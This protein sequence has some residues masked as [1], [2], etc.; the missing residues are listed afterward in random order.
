MF[1]RHLKVILK[2]ALFFTMLFVH[3]NSKDLG[4]NFSIVI[5][6]YVMNKDSK[7]Y[8]CP[9]YLNWLNKTAKL[10]ENKEEYKSEG[11]FIELVKGEQKTE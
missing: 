2:M 11:S 4:V 8:V 7:I 5:F 3:E 6:Y 10:V 1:I 9:A